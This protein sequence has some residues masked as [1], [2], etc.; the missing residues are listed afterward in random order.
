MEIAFRFQ[1][2]DG[3]TGTSSFLYLCNTCLVHLALNAWATFSDCEG[4]V[5]FLSLTADVGQTNAS[6][7]MARQQLTSEDKV[8]EVN[9]TSDC[10]RL[11]YAYA[12]SSAL[13]SPAHQLSAASCQLTFG[14]QVLKFENISS[15]DW[16]RIFR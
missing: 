13:Y 5:S 3:G 14:Q 16:N 8:L 4:E 9:G 12:C 15:D 11:C 7:R 10:V 6:R 2:F 1:S